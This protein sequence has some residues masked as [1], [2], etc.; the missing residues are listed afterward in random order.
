MKVIFFYFLLYVSFSNPLRS[1]NHVVSRDGFLIGNKDTLFNK[2]KLYY[3]PIS[4]LTSPQKQK[5]FQTSIKCLIE[6][7]P[8]QLTLKEFDFLSNPSVSIEEKMNFFQ[9]S[10]LLNFHPYQL[11]LKQKNIQIDSVFIMF[12]EVLM[13]S[14]SKMLVSVRLEGRNA[15]SGL[16]RELEV[17]TCSCLL[18]KYNDKLPDV[19]N[20]LLLIKTKS[21]FQEFDRCLLSSLKIINKNSK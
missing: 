18:E 6:T 2:I 3:E 16:V 20:L 7:I 15:P 5:I 10:N 14:V 1:Q 12:S 19:E 9:K 21:F 11:C 4:S 17:G 13:W 8:T